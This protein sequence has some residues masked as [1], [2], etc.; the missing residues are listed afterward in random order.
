MNRFLKAY[1]ADQAL[2]QAQKIPYGT[3][4][5]EL[6]H[7]IPGQAFGCAALPSASFCPIDESVE[8]SRP[9]KAGRESSFPGS[10]PND[11]SE[12]IQDPAEQTQNPHVLVSASAAKHPV[13][14]KT[15]PIL[16]Q[17]YEVHLLGAH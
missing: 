2:H 6:T 11:E 15:Y 17:E 9:C 13:S 14:K 16:G 4:N 1:L 8:A 12:K 7:L 5:R 10:C 3:K